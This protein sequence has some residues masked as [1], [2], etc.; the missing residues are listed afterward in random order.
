MRKGLLLIVAFA[1]TVFGQ[2]Y[3]GPATGSVAS[4]VSINVGTF[5]RV[6]VTPPKEERFFNKHSYNPDP[7]YIPEGGSNVDPLKLYTEDKAANRENL[8]TAITLL[9]RNFNGINQT[10]SIPPDPYCA[11]GPTHIMAT[12]NSS[13]AIWDKKGNHVITVDADNFYSNLASGLGVFDPKVLYDHF[14]KRWIMVWLDQND[15]TQTAYFVVSVSDDSI[16]TGTWYNWLMSSTLNGSTATNAWGDYQGVGFDQNAIYITSNQ[17]AFGGSYQYVKI[18]IIP[19][20]QLLNGPGAITWSDLWD[21]RYP[22]SMSSRIFNLRPSVMYSTSGDYYLLHAPSGGG[23][24]FSLYKIKDVLTTPT[25][26]GVNVPVANYGNAPNPNQL[27]GGTLRLEG[28]GSAIRNEPKY[29][30]GYLYAVHATSNPSNANYSTVHYTKIDV[31][32]NTVAEQAFFG[33]I[34]F[35]YFYPALEIDKNHNIVAKYSRSGD[36]AYAGAFYS[37]KLATDPPGFTR[38]YPLRYGLANYQKDFQSGRNRWGDYNGVHLD[39]VTETNIWMF[40]EYVVAQNTWATWWGEVRLIPYPGVSVFR[41][42]DKLVFEP[43]EVGKVSDTLT[44]VIANYG[45]TEFLITS[46]T[47][48]QSEFRVVS[49]HTFPISVRSYDTLSIKIVFEPTQHRLYEDSLRMVAATGT[50]YFPLTARGY[51]ITPVAEKQMFGAVKTGNILTINKQT[52]AATVLGPSTYADISALAINHKTNIMYG[53]VNSTS[54][55]T[56]VRVNAAGGDAY[57]LYTLPFANVTSCAFDTSGALFAAQRTGIVYKIDLATGVATYIDSIKTNVSSIAFHPR[58]NELWAS[59]YRPVGTGRDRIIKVNL[60]TGDTTLVG[61][62]GFGVVTNDIEFD[63]AGLLY[64]VKGTATA[65]NDLFLINT[66]TG[67]GTMIASMGVQNVSAIAYSTGILTG[68]KD[69][70]LSTGERPDNFYLGQ[71]YPNPFNPSTVI[72]YGLPVQAEVRLVV[73]NLLGEIVSELVNQSQ[74]PG[75]YQVE[76]SSSALSKSNITSGVYFYELKAKG[77]NLNFSE[78]KKM[79]MLK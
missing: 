41:V 66:S 57:K 29:R 62:T 24:F 69:S 61:V 75:N 50:E 74:N 53:F 32:T 34:G 7:M 49:N 77:E 26:T 21:I 39:P 46:L 44:A 60:G 79:V 38:S 1:F 71:N 40:G 2:L 54:T 65:N 18:R 70:K 43:V 16:P 59:V 48:R 25:M 10:N 30:D 3:Q 67:T 55:S 78:I 20:Q 15:A 9:L 36:T 5:D 72:S 11:V 12:V 63:E 33:A 42:N 22:H 28:G 51:I 37:T 58:T 17:F 35:W 31:S 6:I 23:N 8:D 27:G 14:A 76:F 68:I 45:D 4:G 52:G 64:G 73:Y 19:K 47:T 13:F 56:L